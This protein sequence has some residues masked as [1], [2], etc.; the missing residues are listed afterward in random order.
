MKQT[1]ALVLNGFVLKIIAILTMTLDHVGLAMNADAGSPLYP[2]MIA[3]RIIGR[4]AFPVFALLLAEGLRHTH[5][6]WRYILRLAIDWALILIVDLILVYGFHIQMLSQAFTDLLCFALFITLLESKNK[7]LRF[8]SLLPLLFICFSYWAE[9]DVNFNVT[10]SPYIYLLAGYSLFGFIMFLGFYYAPKM[11][12]FFLKKSEL[13]GDNSLEEYEK[14]LEFQVLVN[15]ISC[16]IFLADV[17]IFWG[18]SYI[19]VLENGNSPYDAYGMS[20]QSYCL[21]AMVLIACYNGKRG[22]N[23][24]WFQYGAYVYYP[25][26]MAIIFGIAF[27]I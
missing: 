12:S 27:L 15:V 23:G 5:S 2:L 22:Y 25:I 24:K 20:I 19:G 1:K 18:I 21:L 4:F 26:H 9:I 3:F 11:A 8:L 13:L 17:L 16:L 14:T 7:K 10:F 6:R